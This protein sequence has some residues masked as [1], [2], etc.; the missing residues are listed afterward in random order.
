MQPDPMADRGLWIGAAR[1]ETADHSGKDVADPPAL[2]PGASLVYCRSRPSGNRIETT[3]SIMLTATFDTRRDA[4]R[5]VERLVQEFDSD[6]SAIFVGA[7]G[8][9]NSAG[10]RPD[11]ADTGDGSASSGDRQDAALGGSIVVSVT[12]DGE[13]TADRVRDA[14]GEFDAAGVVEIDPEKD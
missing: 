1:E 10:V 5:A 11:G 3:M 2:R 4:D 12:V 14:Y 7:D 9:R 13:D 8:E 6:R